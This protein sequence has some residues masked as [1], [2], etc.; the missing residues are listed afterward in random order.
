MLIKVEYAGVN[1]AECLQ[2]QGAYP[3]PPGA[4]DVLG[5]EC[6][7]RIVLNPEK[8]A[9]EAPELSEKVYLALLSGGG[10]AQ[11]A[12]VQRAHTI[13]IPDGHDIQEA[14]SITEV[15]ATAF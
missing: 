4:T 7:G 1:R 3:A 6:C 2:R 13:E 15:Y 11:Y 8:L 12:K 10:Y 9:T 14:A 5:L